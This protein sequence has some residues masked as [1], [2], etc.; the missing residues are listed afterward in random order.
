MSRHWSMNSGSC[1][2]AEM[3]RT[4]SS[5]SPGGIVSVSM[6]EVKPYLYSLLTNSWMVSVAVLMA[7]EE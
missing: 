6:S 5:F 2:L 4:I 1:F 7:W 3:T